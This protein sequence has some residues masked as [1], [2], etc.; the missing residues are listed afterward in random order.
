MVVADEERTK[1]KRSL[2][3]ATAVNE[4]ERKEDSERARGVQRSMVLFVAGA[5][6]VAIRHY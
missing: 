5:D 2:S 4:K 6:D 1:R 3:T